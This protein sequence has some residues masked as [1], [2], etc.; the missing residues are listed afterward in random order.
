[1]LLAKDIHKKYKVPVLSGVTLQ[2]EPG[3]IIG[4]AGENGSGKS[5]L[6]AIIAGL[7]SPDTGRVTIDGKPLIER[8]IGY[9]PQEGTLFEN[10]SVKDN[11]RFWASAYDRPWETA[12]SMLPQDEGFIKKRAGHLSGGMK[13]RLSIALA[14]LHHPRWLIMDEP[15]AAL[16]IGFKGY[17]SQMIQNVKSEGRGVIFTS[18]QPDELMWCDRVYVL[19][20]GIFVYSGD[21]KA[22]NEQALYALTRGGDVIGHS[23][24]DRA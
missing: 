24:H 12:L 3:E 18:H 17:L 8:Q 21:P 2:A 22:L 23:H 15:S 7:T 14:C 9:V 10:L 1:M 6:L 4:L 13:K 20:D 16:D 5:T 19:H 11:L